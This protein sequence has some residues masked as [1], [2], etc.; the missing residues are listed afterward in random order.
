MCIMCI[1]SGPCIGNKGMTYPNPGC[2]VCPQF[3]LN[4][5]LYSATF[6]FNGHASV[7]RSLKQLFSTR[8]AYILQADSFGK[9]F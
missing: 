6:N 7:V 5:S 4:Y 1:F 2:S 3:P 8:L 9:Y